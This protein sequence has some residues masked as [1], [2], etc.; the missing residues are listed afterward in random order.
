MTKSYIR[1]KGPLVVSNGYKVVAIRPNS[2][3]PIGKAWQEH[4]LTEKECAEYP[5]KAAGVGILCG[6]GE[7]P[8]CCLDIDCSDESIVE[9]FLNEIGFDDT[10][11]VRTGRA[12]R[13]AVLL[14]AAEAGWKSKA[15]RFLEKDG[16]VIRLEVLGKG[17]QIVAY[18]IHEKTQMPYTW[19]NADCK[20]EPAY[21]P[22]EKLPDTTAEHVDELMQGFEKIAIAHGYKP[23]G[24]ASGGGNKDDDRFGTEPCGLTISQAREIVNGAGIDKP[25]YNTY[26]RVGMALHFEFQGDEEAM[27]IWNEWACDKPGYRD[28]ES[29]AYKWS[30]FNRGAHDDPVTM[31]WL[32]KEFNKYHDNFE[33]GT[34]EFDLSKR[35]YKLFDGKL[36]RLE[37]YDEWYL[38][39]GKHWDRIGNDYLTALVAQSIEHIMFRAAKDAPEEL[40]K[41]AWSE[42]GKF[43][44]KA[45]SLVSRV[46]TNMKREFAHLVKANDFDKG[47]QYFGVDNGDIDL[48]T[49]D[50]LPPDKRRKISLC[51]AVS[52]DP[53]AKCP[54]WRRTIEECLGSE[55][56][57]FFFQTLMGYALSGTT[58]EELFIILHG[59]GCNGK[60]TLMRILAGVFGE[61]YRAISSDT[62]ASIVKGASTV[63]GARA[64]LIA[65]KGARLVVGQETD[66]GARLN[67]AGIKS[68][69]GGDPVVARQMYSSTVE[70]IDPTWTMILSTNHLPVIK[71]TD[72]GIWRRLVFLE[73]P[74]NFDKD[75]KI[76]KNLNLTDELRKEL[77]GILNWLL[78]G[79]HRYQKEGLDVPDEV[80]FLKEKLREGSDV[81]ERWRTERIEECEIEPGE[82]LKAKDAWSDFL[83]WARDGE[84]EIGQYTKTLFTRKLKEKIEKG[85]LYKNAWMFQGVKLREEEQEEW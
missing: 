41:A 69:T 20:Y 37:N 49:G 81:L 34:T 63:G 14:R 40:Q 79:L 76:K 25:D 50:F 58:K 55:R 64:D 35:M 26:I 83:R 31:R 61:Y 39:N 75:P 51:S 48:F 32:I 68:M 4:P 10:D 19:D 15:T 71:A 38:F 23:V 66:E 36:K 70:T 80:R 8:I 84:E 57:A 72:D 44:A 13:K 17:K 45:S 7:N 52:Y 42:Y 85:R 9:E 33:N 18:H 60:S 73:F 46:V 6:V 78:E 77:P 43:K 12:P 22:A 30:T 67:E 29:L 82:G 2:K 54:R 62:F 5:E 3:A 74:R 24:Q 11:L 47:T 56:L 53:E 27:L 65:L 21:Y 16:V 1:E 59:A 28:Y